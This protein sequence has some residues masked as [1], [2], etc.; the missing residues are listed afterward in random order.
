MKKEKTEYTLK[1]I[2]IPSSSAKKIMV[3]EDG[4]K[5]YLKF[6]TEISLTAEDE[7]FEADAI[8][9]FTLT[10]DTN[11]SGYQV[12]NDKKITSKDVDEGDLVLSISCSTEGIYITDQNP[13]KLKYIEKLLP[14]FISQLNIA[15]HEHINYLIFKM[16]VTE[17]NRIPLSM[18]RSKITAF[19]KKKVETT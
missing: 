10:I 12:K 14:S 3:P 11:V 9:Q 6:N 15:A 18:F 1:N 17:F 13:S 16:N 4:T 19:D 8:K 2:S 5:G 7:E